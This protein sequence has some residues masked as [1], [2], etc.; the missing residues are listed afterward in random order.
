MAT[1]KLDHTKIYSHDEILGY[2]HAEG[3]TFT[4]IYEI[5]S[6]SHAKNMPERMTVGA[7]NVW[8]EYKGVTYEC[9]HLWFNTDT[10]RDEVIRIS[11]AQTRRKGGVKGLVRELHDVSTTTY[12][13]KN[14]EKRYC[15]YKAPAEDGPGDFVITT[16]KHKNEQSMNPL[17]EKFEKL[18]LINK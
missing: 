12:K 7:I 4:M 15:I 18:G 5:E 10:C 11:R 14:G 6:L 13:G 2:I 3:G 16:L 8:I 17:R 1:T 9:D